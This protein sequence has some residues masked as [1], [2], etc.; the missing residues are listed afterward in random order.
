MVVHISR[1]GG[2]VVVGLAFLTFLPNIFGQD[3]SLVGF[4]DFNSPKDGF[5][6]SADEIVGHRREDSSQSIS[7]NESKKFKGIRGATIIQPRAL[8]PEP[9][10]F[11]G[12]GGGG[13]KKCGVSKL[14][15]GRGGAGGEA[16]GDCQPTPT[17]TS[18]PIGTSSTAPSSC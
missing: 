11:K 16:K 10:Q 17:S 14:S 6:I 5:P 9:R 18:P 4:E 15:E 2:M 7:K 13:N 3:V 12:S 8:L 1:P